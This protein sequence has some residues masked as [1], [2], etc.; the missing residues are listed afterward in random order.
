MKKQQQGNQEAA[1]ASTLH[2]LERHQNMEEL[3]G[4]SNASLFLTEKS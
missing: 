1:A 2:R 4:D 3:A